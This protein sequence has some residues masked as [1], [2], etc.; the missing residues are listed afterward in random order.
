MYTIEINKMR[1]DFYNASNGFIVNSNYK[2]DY[3]I[4]LP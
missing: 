1:I 4:K 2:D 3:I